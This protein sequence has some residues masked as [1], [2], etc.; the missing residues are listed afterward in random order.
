MKASLIV[1]HSHPLTSAAQP[2]DIHKDYPPG[3]FRTK[4]LV[5]DAL[6]KTVALK[7]A[8]NEFTAFQTIGPWRTST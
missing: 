7:A 2:P 8:R 5:W 6:L 3:S 4:N 1:L